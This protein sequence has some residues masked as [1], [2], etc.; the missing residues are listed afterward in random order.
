MSDRKYQKEVIEKIITAIEDGKKRILLVA[1]TGS[2]KTRMVVSALKKIGGKSFAVAHRIEIRKQ[3]EREGKRQN[4]TIEASGAGTGKT[5]NK[6]KSGNFNTIFLDEAHHSPAKTYKAL[7][8]NAGDC[9]MVAATAT[10]YRADGTSVKQFFDHIIYAP[11]ERMLTEAG[12]LAKVSY[13]ST[14]AVDFEGVKIT[15][16][17]EFDEKDALN[18][19]R[20]Y[21]QA[22]DIV[23]A[24]GQYARGK[25]ALIYTINLEHAEEIYQELTD[26]NVTCAIVSNRTGARDRKNSINKFQNNEIRALINCQ[27]FTEGS[28][29]E[30]VG[31]I[32]MLR[33]TNSRTLYKQMIGRG[34]R[35]DEDCVVIDHVGNFLRHGNVMDENIADLIETGRLKDANQRTGVSKIETSYERMRLH[36][37]KIEDD[38]KFI[39][40]PTIFEARA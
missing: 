15:K 12:Y 26:A 36:I 9:I 31:A 35:P 25:N 14:D 19:V 39:W 29:I 28:D 38:M 30:N 6:I 34:M 27:V 7:I 22:G 3:I 1:P 8:E 21:V 33:P 2:G 23:K 37:E 5:I 24:W 40:K 4:F 10:P 11:N 13:V 17:E 20:I 32:I 16:K 18:R